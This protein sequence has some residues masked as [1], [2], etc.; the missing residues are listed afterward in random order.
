MNDERRSLVATEQLSEEA[1]RRAR[2]APYR[3]SQPESIALLIYHR[4]GVR[5]LPLADGAKLVIG[6]QPPADVPLGDASLSRQHARVERRGGQVRI[7]DLGSTNGTWLRRERV[8]SADVAPGDALHFGSVLAMVQTT[9]ADD[10]GLPS[11]EGHDRFLVELGAEVRRAR[12]FG[13]STALLMFRAAPGSDSHV[14]RWLPQMRRQLRPFDRISLYSDDTLEVL[15]PEMDDEGARTLADQLLQATDDLRCGLATC[16]GHADSAELLQ[17][18]TVRAL[19]RAS[20]RRPRSEAPQIT[21]GAIEPPS[22]VSGPVAASPAMREV[23][24]TAKRLASTAIPV[25]ILGETGTG[26]EIVAQVLHTGG[27][28]GDRPFRCVN[29]GAIPAQLVESTLFGHEQGAF[30]GADR[31]VEGVFEAADGGTV[32]LD[33]VGELSLAVQ[34]ALLRVLEDKRVTRVGSSREIEVDVRVIAATHRDLD[35]MCLDGEFR[36]DLLYRLNTMALRVPPLRDRPEDIGP[37]IARFVERANTAN[38]CHVRGLEPDALDRLMAYAW[39]GN[40][41]ELRNAIE[42][43]VVIARSEVIVAGDLPGPIRG[44]SLG[45]VPSQ[46]GGETVEMAPL[47]EEPGDLREALARHEARLIR[48]ALRAT[49]DSR[50]HAAKLLNLPLRTMAHKMSVHGIRLRPVKDGSDSTG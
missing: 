10:R 30:T 39:P 27:K 17:A 38:D 5:T 9:S 50:K 45:A 1:L 16:P 24:E 3:A 26:K 32:L 25:L 12:A 31:K 19:Q 48:A 18:V 2:S 28:R 43:A 4:D 40:I 37:L 41:R 34:V 11:L 15:V 21:L 13:R 42:R 33:E 8:E 6:R 36:H 14:G 29:C 23:L 49:G 46:A 44:V 22:D 47:D 20:A 35:Q 7:E